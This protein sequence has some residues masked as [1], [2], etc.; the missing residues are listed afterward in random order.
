MKMIEATNIKTIDDIINQIEKVE[1]KNTVEQVRSEPVKH[2]IQELVKPIEKIIIEDK[3]SIE[4][5]E[6]K[7][8]ELTP[9]DEVLINSS[10]NVDL[11]IV[12][13]IETDDYSTPFDDLPTTREVVE[14]KKE[15]S[16]AVVNKVEEEVKDEELYVEPINEMETQANSNIDV[17]VVPLENAEEEENELYEQLTAKI[18]DRDYALGEC[19]EKNFIFNGYENNKLYIISHAQDEERKFLYKYFGLIRTF[20]QDIFG[21]DVE[22]DFKK[23][24]PSPVENKTSEVTPSETKVEEI[25]S[26]E[27]DNS[28][29]SG[30]MIE[31]IEMSA[32]CVA[33]MHKSSKPTPSQQE[34]QLND[35][36]NS[37][38]LDK[39]KE[40]F[41][42]K[43]ITVKS[44][45]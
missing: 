10:E 18:Y 32:G 43:K 14:P 19:F 45:S 12:D 35:I 39:A 22:L 29:D 13:S 7:I 20:A 33:D 17:E 34:L 3:S 16:Q 41:D 8:E 6:T 4:E 37:K 9:F 27:D 23:E 25:T 40:L 38:M 30:S 36:I 21:N 2:T 26:S 44:R 24:E 5:T 28:E 42:I 1:T 11:D 31:S 15:V